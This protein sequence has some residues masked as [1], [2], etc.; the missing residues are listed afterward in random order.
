MS[1]T[2][3]DEVTSRRHA[4]VMAELDRVGWRN[5]SVGMP[6]IGTSL[7]VNGHMVG[8]VMSIEDRTI[9]EVFDLEDGDGVLPGLVLREQVPE[10]RTATHDG[11]GRVVA[12][13]LVDLRRLDPGSVGPAVVRGLA[14]AT[15]MYVRERWP[16]D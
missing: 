14:A 5:G 15:V 11:L 7:L 8:G 6:L 2:S 3:P 10:V 16:D 9:V 13:S 4:A 12:S 1:T